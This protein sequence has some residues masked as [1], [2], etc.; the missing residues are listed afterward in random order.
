MAA[1]LI[2]TRKGVGIELRRGLFDIQLDGQS[3]GSITRDQTVTTPLEPGHHAVRIRKGR[4]T[5]QELSFD[6][7]EGE[8]VNLRTH[9]AMVWPRF[10]ASI[11]KPDLAISLIRE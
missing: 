10:V 6:V 1:T 7:E 3:V 11:I 4:Y 2:L 8:A 9:G 5:S